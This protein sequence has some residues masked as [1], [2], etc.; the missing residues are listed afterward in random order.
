MATLETS[1][2]TA[3]RPASTAPAPLAGSETH[4]SPDHDEHGL[5][6][7]LIAALNARGISTGPVDDVAAATA[8]LTHVLRAAD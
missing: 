4:R 6:E 5:R 8:R 7:R 1:P 3:Q 2:H